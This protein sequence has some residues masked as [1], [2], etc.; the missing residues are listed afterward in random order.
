[1]TAWGCTHAYLVP[2]PTLASR[3]VGVMDAFIMPGTLELSMT[4]F[5]ITDLNL[6]FARRRNLVLANGVRTD[7]TPSRIYIYTFG[8]WRIRLVA[9]KSGGLLQD[10]KIG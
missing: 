5:D 4:A 1:M 9:W 6:R 7:T 10:R 3:T 2:P 8:N